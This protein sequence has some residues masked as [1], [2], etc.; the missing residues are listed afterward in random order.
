MEDQEAAALA[1]GE[2]DA[3]LDGGTRAQEVGHPSLA[4]LLLSTPWAA[5]EDAQ[6]AR[7]YVL[8]FIPWRRPS[9]AYGYGQ[10]IASTWDA[11]RRS[12]GR[13]YES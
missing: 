9:S 10:V 4:E 11:Y 3:V 12:T 2:R 1:C 7:R 6:P 13:R 8:G 5:I